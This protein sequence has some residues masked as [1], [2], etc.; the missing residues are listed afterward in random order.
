MINILQL[1][2]FLFLI[3]IQKGSVRASSTHFMELRV[4]KSS[5]DKEKLTR[6]FFD[7][8]EGKRLY[9]GLSR[10]LF[11]KAK[12]VDYEF[13]L[14]NGLMLVWRGKIDGPFWSDWEYLYELRLF[15]GIPIYLRPPDLKGVSHD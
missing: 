10:T 8:K 3:R 15:E 9:N 7:D 5:G 12:S 1:W 13:P 2:I 11:Y 14:K 6:F 4:R